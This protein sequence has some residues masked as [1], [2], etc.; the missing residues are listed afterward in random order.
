[1]YCRKINGNKFSMFLNFFKLF[2]SFFDLFLIFFSMFCLSILCLFY[3]FAFLCFVL[4][5]FVID[6]YDCPKKCITDLCMHTPQPTIYG[7]GQKVHLRHFPWPKCPGLNVLGR[8][9]RSPFNVLHSFYIYQL[10]SQ[11]SEKV[12]HIKGN[13][14]NKQ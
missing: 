12:T 1:M 10:H 9:I 4:L 2:R 5:C 6:P 13:Y 3:I 14:W 11:N 8:N 7:Y